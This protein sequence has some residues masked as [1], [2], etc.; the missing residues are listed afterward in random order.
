MKA[1][2]YKKTLIFSIV[3]FLTIALFVH[4]FFDT[5]GE[6][7]L[8][9]D[10]HQDQKLI[11][12]SDYS[13]PPQFAIWLENPATGQLKT[14][15]V[16][17]SSAQG[18]WVGKTE[19]P[20]SLPLWFEVFKKEYQVNSLPGRDKLLPI[21]ITGATPQDEHFK[22]CAE[23]PFDSEW[24]CWMEVNLAGDFN[25]HF[26]SSGDN[27]NATLDDSGQASIVYKARFKSKKGAVIKPEIVGY[28]DITKDFD[29]MIQPLEGI[30]TAKDIFKDITIRVIRPKPALFK[31]SYKYRKPVNNLED[32][33]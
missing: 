6:T 10:I 9:F 29:N 5:F 19:C 24:I 16:T 26:D 7:Q 11:L 13:E 18:E 15:F 23:V 30:S 32:V 31:W 33:K 25:E 20:G 22:V 4:A 27:P 28:V 2:K 1:Y 8:E 3:S 12:F 14:V 21:A 17:R